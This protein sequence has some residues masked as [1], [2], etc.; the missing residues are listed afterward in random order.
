MQPTTVSVII[1]VKNSA[2]YLP[3]CLDSVAAQTFD[4]YQV[5][6]VDGGSTD[7]TESIA[8]SYDKVSFFQQSGTGFGDAWNCGLARAR[9]EFLTFIDSDDVWMPRKLALQ[10]AILQSD[11]LLEG[12]IGKVRFMLE[13]DQDSSHGFRDIVFAQDHIAYMPGVL[14]ARRRLFDR[15]GD[16]GEGWV[17]ANDIN[18]F[19]KLK[20]SGLP[21]GVIDDVLLNK[22]VHSSNFS[23][24]AAES[25]VYRQEIL[26][27]LH[28][29]IQR[30][31]AAAASV[32]HSGIPKP[33]YL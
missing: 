29:S 22:R 26:R 14:M 13:P 17:V 9:S 10:I 18:W 23:S 24:M 6:V 19:L 11:Q 15:L 12:V 7:A 2:R 21:I 3:E 32:P 27:L 30:K 16:W 33:P 8:R 31:R 4:D 20:D 5:L 25:P 28:S 1:A